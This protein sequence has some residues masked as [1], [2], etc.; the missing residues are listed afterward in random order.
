VNGFAKRLAAA[1]PP[2]Q[3]TRRPNLQQYR[4]RA[5]RQRQRIY[6]IHYREVL[7]FRRN[8][9]IHRVDI[10]ESRLYGPEMIYTM[11]AIG[12]HFLPDPSHE[13]VKAMAEWFADRGIVYLDS[14]VYLN[15]TWMFKDADA[16]LEFRL[17]WS[18]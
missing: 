15:G 16:A 13:T 1:K 3:S 14:Y 8:G 17:T 9:F 6:T 12:G 2:S 5:A 4:T 10:D 18:V 11:P 7:A